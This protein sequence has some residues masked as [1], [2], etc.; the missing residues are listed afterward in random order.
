MTV[1]QRRV[2]LVREQRWGV[3]FWLALVAVIVCALW[4]QP[5]PDEPS[6][7]GA[8]KLEHAL[9]FVLLVWIGLRAGYRN[10]LSLAIGLLALG[11]AVELAQG[12]FT[13]TR[14]ADWFDWFADAAGIALGWATAWLAAR[15]RTTRSIGL[16]QE[17]GR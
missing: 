3:A 5:G 7:P 10:A 2:L 16:E 9:S 4:S 14:S 11:G 6:F 17:H 8:D 1:R 12:S 15:R 13:T